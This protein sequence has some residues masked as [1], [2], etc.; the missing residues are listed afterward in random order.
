M[1]DFKYDNNTAILCQLCLNYPDPPS[2]EF[3]GYSRRWVRR[4]TSVLQAPT[5][6]ED[7]V[8]SADPSMA[9]CQVSLGSFSD[10]ALQLYQY[11]SLSVFL[12]VDLGITWIAP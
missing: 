9:E 2:V 11:Y 5:N 8:K 10:N 4:R 1:A 3:A 6:K 12:A 7:S